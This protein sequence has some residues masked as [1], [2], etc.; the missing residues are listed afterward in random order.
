VSAPASAS[1]ST[2]VGAPAGLL[3]VDDSAVARVLMR[4][5]FEAAGHRV[6]VAADGEEALAL[7]E[8]KRY[9]VLVTDL[10]MPRLDG[11]QL[12]AAL[13]AS[14]ANDD[15]PIV[16]I[17]GHDELSARVHDMKGLYGIFKKPWNDSELLQRV[18]NLAT[19]R[20][21]AANG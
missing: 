18:N 16:A 2:A 4:K 9:S 7:L 21:A 14:P 12:I 13:Q 19:L 15:L 3:V 20:R 5:L 11:F 10:E 1:A 8:S 6:D 17:T